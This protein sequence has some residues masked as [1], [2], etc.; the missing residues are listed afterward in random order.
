MSD[1]T[2]SALLFAGGAGLLAWFSRRSLRLPGSHGFYRYFG[3]LAILAL[4]V[5]N[6][7]RWGSDPLSSRQL[8]AAQLMWASLAFV[9]LG[10]AA[11][12]RYGAPDGS[13]DDETLYRFERTTALV[14]QGIF[15][16]IRHPMYSSLLLLLWSVYLQDPSWTGA[17]IALLGSLSFLL[18]AVADERECLR[19]FGPAYADYMKRTRRFIP[20][21]F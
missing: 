17:A 3:W 4:A 18:T 7:A 12:K 5:L 14:T 19:Y 9:V 8:L 15:R 6:R 13:R 21:L 1:S 10:A 20:W 11:L 2:V 16:L